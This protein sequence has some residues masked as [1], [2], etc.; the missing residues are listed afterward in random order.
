MHAGIVATSLAL[1]GPALAGVLAHTT[2]TVTTD[3]WIDAPSDVPATSIK[4]VATI[5]TIKPA[6]PTE[7]CTPP[8]DIDRHWNE[9]RVL[10]DTTKHHGHFKLWAHFKMP[11]GEPEDIR[12][13]V[14]LKMHEE[15]KDIW[16]MVLGPE[17]NPPENVFQPRW[18]LIK[19][20]LE[21][22]GSAPINDKLYLRLFP[23]ELHGDT[24]G[25]ITNPEEGKK[26]HC[27]DFKG[28]VVYGSML[29]TNKSKRTYH[30][31]ND[32]KLIA[33]DG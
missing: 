1:A 22:D 24:R 27:K 2:S 11:E 3:V 7:T 9:D 19:N 15:R 33:K 17:D 31:E 29:T 28:P 25:W 26:S 14:H 13:A 16:D 20:G 23:S 21:T 32:A 18:N 6:K 5:P 12:L 30:K 8:K 10:N 4:P